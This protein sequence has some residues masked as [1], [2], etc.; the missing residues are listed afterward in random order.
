M[1][2]FI[3]VAIFFLWL[4]PFTQLS[5]QQMFVYKDKNGKALTQAQVDALDKKYNGFL[6]VEFLRDEE[7]MMVQISAPTAQELKVIRDLRAEETIQLQKKW[8]NKPLPVFSLENLSG[9]TRS[10]QD[11]LAKKTV[12]FFFSKND[13]GSLSQW[14]TLDQLAKQYKDKAQFWAITFEDAV[15]IREFLNKHPLAYEIIPNSFSFVMQDLGIM[16]TP[17][18]MILD[19][20]GIVKFLT[21]NTQRRMDLVLKE[22]LA[23]IK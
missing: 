10:N 17:V 9:K 23:K 2:S 18:S 8:M 4:Y 7:P 3:R 15:L 6:I 5:A 11:L 20:K 14:A 1:T 12:V 21:T 13:Y 22:E 19:S 16:Q